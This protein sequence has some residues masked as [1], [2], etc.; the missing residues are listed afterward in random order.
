MCPV[1]DTEATETIRGFEQSKNSFVTVTDE[2]YKSAKTPR[3][4]VVVLHKFVD[5][6]DDYWIDESYWLEPN[7][8]SEH[9]FD[10]FAIGLKLQDKWAL[11]TGAIWGKERP[12]AVE[13]VESEGL[14][15]HILH[16]AQEFVTAPTLKPMTVSDAEVD[17]VT[18]F[19]NAWT[20]P[21]EEADLTTST[22]TLMRSLLSSKLTGEEF[23][24]PEQVEEQPPPADLQAAMRDAIAMKTSHKRKKKAAA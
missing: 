23:V 7:A 9:L 11:G 18:E 1:C 22:D 15:L 24:P 8:L 3:S 17:L 20:A 4:S 5:P 16:T 14:M 19:I 12:Y 2:E 10:V 21:L 13:V 6:M